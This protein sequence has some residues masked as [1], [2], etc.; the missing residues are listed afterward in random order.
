MTQDEV[1]EAGLATVRELGP[2]LSFGYHL[3]LCLHPSSLSVSF[4]I[5]IQRNIKH[6]RASPEQI[7]CDSSRERRS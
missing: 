3:L 1:G 5:P 2:W 7:V 4:L 6:D